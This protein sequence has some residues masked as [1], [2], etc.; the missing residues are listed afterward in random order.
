M[1]R[2]LTSLAAASLLLAACQQGG[3]SDNSKPAKASAKLTITGSSTVAPLSAE[4]GKRFESR[5]SGVQIDVQTGGSSRGV[6]DA[7]Q[8]L[9]DIGDVSRDLSEEET[10]SGLVATAIARDGICV[11]LNSANPVNELTKAQITAVYL[12]KVT[13]LEGGWWQGR[14]HHGHQQG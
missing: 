12:G 9:A 11:I 13:N 6:T 14:A 4:I 10:A 3:A 1:I 5:H 2:R 8:G 7:Q